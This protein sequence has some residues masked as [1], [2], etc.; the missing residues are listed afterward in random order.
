MR[1]TEKQQV[2]C[3]K[4]AEM[5][6]ADAAARAAGYT[7]WREAA[8]R[9]MANGAVRRR[10]E[11]LLYGT[12]SDA[13][14]AATAA[15]GGDEAREVAEP[16]EILQFLTEVMRGTVS[17]QREETPKVSERTKAA[18]LLGRN[19]RLFSEAKGLRQEQ[20]RCVVHIWGEDELAE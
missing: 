14:D 2:F 17:P 6:D 4:Y 1:L 20:P 19:Q 12:V 16:E 8:R 9:N 10:I 13:G 18:E 3:D 5:Q 11:E 15:D 7:K